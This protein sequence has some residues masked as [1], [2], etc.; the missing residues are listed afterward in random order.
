MISLPEFILKDIDD[1]FIRE[2]FKR[3]TLFLQKFPFF[4]GE[5]V[6]IEKTFTA[7]A[8]NL[9]IAHGLGFKPTDI[10]LTSTIGAGAVT[11]NYSSFTDTNIN[12]TVTNSCVIRFFVGAYKEE[13]SRSGR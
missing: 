9:N 11:F 12:V 7:A 4:R 5:W 2:N 1:E 6:F 3:L 13:S 8:T 10:I